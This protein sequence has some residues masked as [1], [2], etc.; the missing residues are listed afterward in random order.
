MTDV[1]ALHCL[2]T[3]RSLD[4]STSGEFNFSF[5]DYQISMQVTNNVDHD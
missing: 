1:S 3:P 2:G 4:R 5:L